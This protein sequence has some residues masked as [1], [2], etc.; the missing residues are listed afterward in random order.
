M[1]RDGRLDDRIANML[2]ALFAGE[3]EDADS[4]LIRE[5]GER[6]RSDRVLMEIVDA[7]LIQIALL[8][9]DS[10]S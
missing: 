5:A 6:L 9:Q 8:M 1:S 7:L 2:A 3:Y 4:D 10:A